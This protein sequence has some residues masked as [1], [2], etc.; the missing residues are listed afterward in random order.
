MRYISVER[1][2]PMDKGAR[3]RFRI[4]DAFLSSPEPKSRESLPDE[5]TEGE[6]AGFSD[7]GTR[8]DAFAIVELDDGQTMIVPVENLKLATSKSSGCEPY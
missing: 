2:Y 8:R 5:E 4:S 1:R 6:I 7:S 3:V